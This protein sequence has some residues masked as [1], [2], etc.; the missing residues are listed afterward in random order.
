MKNRRLAIGVG[1]FIFG[2]LI[3]MSM[4]AYMVLN[5]PEE[6]QFKVPGTAMVSVNKP[7]QYYLWNDH[8]TIFEGKSYICSEDIPDGVEMKISNSDTGETFEFVSSSP[9]SYSRGDNS[10]KSIGYIKAEDPVKVSIEIAGLKDERV[11]SFSRSIFAEMLWVI[12]VA[13]I[14]STVILLVG[15]LVIYN[16]AK[17]SGA[18]WAKFVLRRAK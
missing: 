10:K 13:G 1:L 5:A 18:A 4:L 6:K 7:G 2:F 12:V 9:I 3:Q 16:E 11:F 14:S 15:F 17:K 8:K